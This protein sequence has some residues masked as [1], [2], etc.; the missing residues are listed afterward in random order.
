[1]VVAI[2]TDCGYPQTPAFSMPRV[3]VL[4]GEH[5]SYGGTTCK[6]F[7]KLRLQGGVRFLKSL[8]TSTA[9]FMAIWLLESLKTRLFPPQKTYI[10]Y[11]YFYFSE[12]KKLSI[13]AANVF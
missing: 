1:M 13:F 3:P 8:C 11:Y 5:P 10:F 2:R 7:G 9:S 6:G 4:G 12:K